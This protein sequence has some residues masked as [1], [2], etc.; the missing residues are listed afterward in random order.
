MAN[1]TLHSPRR[2]AAQTAHD[3]YASI[4]VAGA[5]DQ[6]EKK[7]ARIKENRTVERA[8]LVEIGDACTPYLSV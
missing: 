7:S 3:I 2:R 1:R 4:S 6:P 5:V 8:P